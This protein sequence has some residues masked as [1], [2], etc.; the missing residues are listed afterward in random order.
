MIPGD[1]KIPAAYRAAADNS[2][3]LAEL[4][5]LCGKNPGGIRYEGRNL[6]FPAAAS[7]NLEKLA[8]LVGQGVNPDFRDA[9]G[10]SPLVSATNCCWEHDRPVIR[11]LISVGVDLEA[12]SPWGE[13]P[14][15]NSLRVG[16]YEIV[17]ELVEAGADPEACAFSPLHQVA[18]WGDPDVLEKEM[19]GAMHL[20][21]RDVWERTPWLVAVHAGR[22][23]ATRQLEAAGADVTSRDRCGDSAMHLAAMANRADMLRE[24]LGNGYDPRIMAESGET[25]LHHAALWD[26]LLAATVLLKAG[27]EVDAKGGCYSR[28]VN[29]AR[30]VE[31]LNV[32]HRYGADLNYVDDC[33]EWP[34]KSFAED[35][36][37]E[38]VQWLLD[39]GAEVDRSSTG[40][41]ALHVAV[42]ENHLAIARLLLDRGADIN[43]QDVDGETPLCYCRSV[44][45]AEFLLARGADP[46][47][48]NQ[49]DILPEDWTVIPAEV[50]EVI[51]NHGR[52]R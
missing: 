35:G 24:L 8:W 30:G 51:R 26:A 33:G 50:R 21:G 29:H 40:G 17:K 13:S 5:R 49:C 46:G 10:Y 7:G 28:P 20:E 12:K 44:D 37:L 23:T 15:R 36:N 6:A 47:I 11:Y 22:V 3:P 48:L 16:C 25:P 42:Q 27:A 38:A 2:V 14:L 45:A 4:I 41:T 9:H 39:H 52:R 18:A 31:M 19:A 43:R 1:E 32:L 34:L